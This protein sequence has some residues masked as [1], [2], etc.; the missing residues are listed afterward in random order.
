MQLQDENQLTLIVLKVKGVIASFSC[1]MISF[2]WKTKQKKIFQEKKNCKQNKIQ[3]KNRK[4]M[5]K[6]KKNMKNKSQN[7]RKKRLYLGTVHKKD[8]KK[9]VAK[10]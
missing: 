7:S 4:N 1:V 8:A 5:P 10:G 6:R 9:I 3:K 2:F